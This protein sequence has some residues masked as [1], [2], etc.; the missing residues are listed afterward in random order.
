[1]RALRDRGELVVLDEEVKGLEGGLGGLAE[2]RDVVPKRLG[3]AAQQ[4]IKRIKQNA[5]PDRQ[6]FSDFRDR[7]GE[8]KHQDAKQR[9]STTPLLAGAHG[10]VGHSPGVQ[11]QQAENSRGQQ[12]EEQ[13]RDREEKEREKQLLKIENAKSENGEQETAHADQRAPFSHGP[14]SLQNPQVIGCGR[15]AIR[16]AEYARSG[17]IG[18]TSAGELAL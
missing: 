10:K 2:L 12:Q 8:R 5:L 17:R 15:P 11:I 16:S 1:M 14:L 18:R 9:Q 4:A 3:P 7:G 6:D 13:V